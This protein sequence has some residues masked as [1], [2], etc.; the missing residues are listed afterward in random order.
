[1]GMAQNILY[2]FSV[3]SWFPTDQGVALPGVQAL[4]VF[5]LMVIALFLRGSSLPLRGEHV[6]RRLPIVPRV[7]RLLE[8]AVLAL[9]GGAVALLGLLI[10]VSALRV[11]GV[12]LAVVTLGAAVAIE[13]FWFV[14]LTW[15]GGQGGAPVPQPEIFGLNLGNDASFRGID[16]KLPSPMLG[17]LM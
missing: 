17:F 10:G 13:Q 8:P 3:Q 4:L 14:N 9:A 6:E 5:V 1:I 11:R 2:Y 16:G 15:G 7:E 12:Q